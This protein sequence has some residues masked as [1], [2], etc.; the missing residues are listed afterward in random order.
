MTQMSSWAFRNIV[1]SRSLLNKSKYK[2]N[3]YKQ[4][5]QQ[6]DICSMD[7][8]RAVANSFKDRTPTGIDQAR[9]ASCPT[10]VE[11]KSR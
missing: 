9:Q 8:S 10:F 2:S 7:T 1:L 6:R 4:M 11:S 3:N 5:L